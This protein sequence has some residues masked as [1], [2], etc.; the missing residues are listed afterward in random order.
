MA[1]LKLDDV[2]ADVDA[3]AIEPSTVEVP[4]ATEGVA[5]GDG[6]SNAEVMEATGG[7]ADG[8]G[9]S[10]TEEPRATECVDDGNRPST[11]EVTRATG[12]VVEGVGP[13]LAMLSSTTDGAV[14]GDETLSMP[15]VGVIEGAV[16][17]GDT[18]GQGDVPLVVVESDGSR[19]GVED[20][21][22]VFD[23]I[24]AKRRVKTDA[25]T[26]Q[27]DIADQLFVQRSIVIKPIGIRRI[28]PRIRAKYEVVSS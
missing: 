21:G 3:G 27:P 4:R 10:F 18:A 7:V 11:V 1:L 8:V 24:M 19:R 14:E 20:D 28:K 23:R 26:R 6:P 17:G 12:A 25:C 9:I 2:V 16:V 5:D 15:T 22:T 13:S